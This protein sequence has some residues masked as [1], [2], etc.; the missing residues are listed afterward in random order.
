MD[1][2]LGFRRLA[3]LRHIAFFRGQ[4]WRDGAF[5]CRDQWLEAGAA[6]A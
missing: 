6:V 2:Y 5:K 3:G 1:D 4:W